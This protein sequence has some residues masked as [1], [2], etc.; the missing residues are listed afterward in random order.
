MFVY[1]SSLYNDN[2]TSWSQFVG[3]ILKITFTSFKSTKF[4]CHC[5][6][7][8]I[9][10]LLTG[11]LQSCTIK[12]KNINRKTLSHKLE[13]TYH[14]Y[15]CY[16]LHLAIQIKQK[17]IKTLRANVNLSR[18]HNFLNSYKPMVPLSYS[19]PWIQVHNYSI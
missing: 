16:S 9:S 12:Q 14:K 2:A 17:L 7:K 15:Y 18:D 8:Y 11:K 13:V 1:P 6:K 5:Y 10:Y 19:N 4:H 3:R